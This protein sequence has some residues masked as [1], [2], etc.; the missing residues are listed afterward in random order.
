MQHAIIKS[1]LGVIVEDDEFISLVKL[2]R[3][4]SQPAKKIIKMVEYGVI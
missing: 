2:C 3:H 4:C 1:D